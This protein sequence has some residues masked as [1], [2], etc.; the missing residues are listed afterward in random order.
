MAEAEEA[1]DEVETA[2]RDLTDEVI[3]FSAKKGQRPLPPRKSRMG[4]SYANIQEK[5][6]AA[7]V[8]SAEAATAATEA[9]EEIAAA[10]SR[11]SGR[12]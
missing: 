8:A 11:G 6:D 7:A 4:R 12:H 10:A 2:T 1:T 3:N 9:A 5:T